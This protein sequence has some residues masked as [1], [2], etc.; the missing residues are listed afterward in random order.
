M[1]H[2]NVAVLA[3]LQVNNINPA[4]FVEFTRPTFNVDL[5]SEY[6]SF[7]ENNRAQNSSAQGI[8]NM[9]FAFPLINDGRK[10]R[11]AGLAFGLT[12][13][14]RVGYNLIV[15]SQVEDI[16]D[17]EY[18]FTGSGGVNQ[19]F[20]G[21]GY[22]LFVDSART[23]V[24]CLGASVNYLFGQINRV[25]ATQFPISSLTS[26]LYRLEQKE[27][28]D[29]DFHIGVLF[30]HRFEFYSKT[31]EATS[32][33]LFSIGAYLRP[34]VDVN[35]FF[36]QNAYSYVDALPGRNR[37][38]TISYSK[39]RGATTMPIKYGVGA[40]LN[41]NNRWV[42]AVDYHF[43]GWSGLSFDG[44]NQQLNDASSWNAGLEYLPDYKST[45]F[46]ESLRYRTGVSYVNGMQ[47]LNGGKTIRLGWSGG[48]GIPL[49]ASLSSSIFNLGIEIANRSSQ[50]ASVNETFLII[51]AGM[52][53]T[54]HR[55]DGWF[56]K[57]KF[58]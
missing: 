47:A 29:V 32:P 33:A 37:I 5:R 2:A 26:S 15:D 18:R 58:D 16:G 36:T 55:Y 50:N 51:Q 49:R 43:T 35:T 46:F 20:L 28:S 21:L 40:S 42:V 34:S 11:R 53:I 54:P 38:D 39:R 44:K 13:L 56:T 24:L 12:P 4:T 23:N 30:K 25:R 31:D 3:P 1:G 27:F 45:R 10:K 14:T 41:L 7:S 22:D 48:L 17:V 19:V 8:Q 52:A 57:R 6:L 9:S